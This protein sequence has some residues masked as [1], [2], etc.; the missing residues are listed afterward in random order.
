[1]FKEWLLCLITKVNRALESLYW[2]LY[3]IICKI[4]KHWTFLKERVY[5]P[6]C[7]SHEISHDWKFLW[8]SLRKFLCIRKY[9][10]ISHAFNIKFT[11]RQ[12]PMYMYY[13]IFEKYVDLHMIVNWEI[14]FGLFSG[15]A[16][17]LQTNY[18]GDLRN[19]L[20]CVFDMNCSDPVIVLDES[21]K[22]KFDRHPNF[23]A[24][25]TNRYGHRSIS[26]R[27]RGKSGLWYFTMFS[28]MLF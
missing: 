14:D 10:I 24:R 11:S 13:S 15:V 4:S 9:K 7:S 20:K 2:L 17:Q 25:R 26:N 16:D 23:M 1:M 5:T 19:I 12:L 8:K 6:N 27:P 21:P 28:H 3:L 22:K 18:A